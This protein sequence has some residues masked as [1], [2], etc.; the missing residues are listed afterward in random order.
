LA[1]IQE[2][3]AVELLAKTDEIGKMLTG[4]KKSLAEKIT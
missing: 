1:F 3:D 4:L 2:N